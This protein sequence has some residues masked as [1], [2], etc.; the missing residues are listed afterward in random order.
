MTKNKISNDFFITNTFKSFLDYYNDLFCKGYTEEMEKLKVLKTKEIEQNIIRQNNMNNIKIK[1][2]V[3]KPILEY[4]D[5][6]INEKITYFNNKEKIN[7]EIISSMKNEM[8][9]QLKLIEEK[10]KIIENKNDEIIQKTNENKKILKMISEKCE[11]NKKLISENNV[12]IIERNIKIEDSIKYVKKVFKEKMNKITNK[13]IQ[14]L[15]DKIENDFINIS[16]YHEKIK[17]IEEKMKLNIKQNKKNKNENKDINKK[18][19]EKINKIEKTLLKNKNNNNNRNIN[20]NNFSKNNDKFEMNIENIKNNN[21]ENTN[22]SNDCTKNNKTILFKENKKLNEK[23]NDK[24]IFGNIYDDKFT[25]KEILEL[26]NIDNLNHNN[27]II[28]F[29]LIENIEIIK[30]FKI[31]PCTKETIMKPIYEKITEK[32][33]NYKSLFLNINIFTKYTNFIYQ[34]NSINKNEKKNKLM[35]Q[36]NLNSKKNKILL[37][38]ISNF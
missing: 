32:S 7:D 19:F 28:G 18:I 17:K 25:E 34:I 8:N 37:D 29:K 4:I 5:D 15:D 2:F 12:L 33:G 6:L 26:Y 9:F 23:N 20:N 27:E 16:F 31:Y 11:E 30:Y 14:K 1:E 35:K 10:Q 3:N 36:K 13:Y 38:I 24:K 21:S 22:F